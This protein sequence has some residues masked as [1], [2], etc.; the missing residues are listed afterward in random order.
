MVKMEQSGV[1]EDQRGGVNN[2]WFLPDHFL[3]RGVV[4]TV[5]HVGWCGVEN[6]KKKE[7]MYLVGDTFTS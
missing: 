3:Y 6:T 2:P 5:V 4:R 1:E 7:I